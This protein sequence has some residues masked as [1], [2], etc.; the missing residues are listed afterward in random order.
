MYT[1]QIKKQELKFDKNILQTS[2]ESKSHETIISARSSYYSR[3]SS[4]PPVRK[5]VYDFSF[6]AVGLMENDFNAQGLWQCL[7]FGI[8][9]A[10]QIEIM[11]CVHDY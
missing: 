11:T 2:I 1:W 5:T 8:L 10:S 6:C 9:Q 3:D 7:P 4:P